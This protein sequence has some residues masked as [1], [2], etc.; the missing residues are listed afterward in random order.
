M[1]EKLDAFTVPVGVTMRWPTIHDVPE[2]PRLPAPLLIRRAQIG[3]AGP[4]AALLSR[5]FDAEHWDAAGT[6]LELFCDETVKATLV[7]VAEERL[8]ATVSLQVDTDVPKCGWVRW[9][10][11]EKDWRRKGLARALVI[12]ALTVAAQVGCR[13]TRLRTET[14]RLAAIAMYLQ[15]GF[16]PLV[17]GDQEREVWQRVRRLIAT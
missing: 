16:E 17:H 7:V 2:M 11:T 1:S 8:V 6:E 14:D 15:L 13:E 9:V 4:L 10:A 12:S 3:E 5:A